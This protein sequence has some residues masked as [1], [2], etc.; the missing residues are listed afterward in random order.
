MLKQLIVACLLMTGCNSEPKHEPPAR[1]LITIKDVQVT[2]EKDEPS[3]LSLMLP[4]IHEMTAQQM[5]KLPF[6]EPRHEYGRQ[7]DGK[8]RP[9]WEEAYF[10][11]HTKYAFEGGVYYTMG[12]KPMVPQV[13]ADFI[14]DTIDRA[15]GTWYSSDLKHPKKIIGK[16]NFRKE[17]LDSK[18]EPRNASHLIKFFDSHP[19]DFEMIFQGDGMEVGDANA[20]KVWMQTMKVQIGD[21][22]IIRGKAPWDHGKE[23]HWHSFFVTRVNDSGIPYMI[24]GNA[25]HPKE[26]MVEDE[27]KRAPK[28]KVVAII[29]MTN[30]FLK[31]LQ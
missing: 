1:D 10:N 28:R 11:K 29:R 16:L 12:P 6:D 7:L 27:V 19:D 30:S 17:I 26:V 2:A 3:R 31:K 23:I 20:L 21:I 15:A 14:V 13:C 9:Y 4:I 24:M 25:G 22:V 8:L 18:L 5:D